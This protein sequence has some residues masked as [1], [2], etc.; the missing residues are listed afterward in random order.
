MKALYLAI[1][2]AIASKVPAIRW[3]DFDMG[4]LDVNEPPV[5]WPCVLVDFNSSQVESGAENTSLELTSVDVVIG[6]KLRERTHSKTD[7]AFRDEALEHL[8]TV[9][10]VRVALQGLAGSGFAGLS[11]TGFTRDKRSDYRVYRQRYT[12]ETFPSSPDSKYIPWPN[13]T[14]P[15]FC[16]HPD[17]E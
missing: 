1:N 14:G 8:D 16:V 12:C 7:T 9:D 13:A 11:Y 10:A 3:V 17:I 5:S 4:Q 6:F 2:A 15:D